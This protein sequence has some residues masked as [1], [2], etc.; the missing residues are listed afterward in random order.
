MAKLVPQAK[1]ITAFLLSK[2]WT[3]DGI[4]I[5]EDEPLFYLLKPPAQLGIHDKNFRYKV[6]IKEMPSPPHWDYLNA[7]VAGIATIYQIEK[8]S[9]DK[10]LFKPLKVIIEN[11][12][13]ALKLE[14]TVLIAA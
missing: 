3:I 9:L 8:K 7:I 12:P 14:K 5:F 10:L 6:Y 1:T 4:E 13:D 11:D 2:N